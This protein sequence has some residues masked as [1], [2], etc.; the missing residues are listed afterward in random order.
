MCTSDE[1]VSNLESIANS[2]NPDDI[3]VPMDE[4]SIEIRR[5]LIEGIERE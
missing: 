2:I 4:E 3:D 5:I 1:R